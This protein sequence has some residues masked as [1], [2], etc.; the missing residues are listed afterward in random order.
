MASAAVR[1]D[2]FR[3]L[4]RALNKINRQAAGGFRNELKPAAEPVA[5]TARSRLSRYPGASLSTIGP[6]SVTAGVFVT[7][8]ARKVTGRRPDFGGIVMRVGLLPALDE[9]A[10]DVVKAVED[11]LDRLGRREG[12]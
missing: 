11:A 10:D 3:E 2:G 6:R 4:N 9:H 12:F 5:A 8:R 7:Q 1:L